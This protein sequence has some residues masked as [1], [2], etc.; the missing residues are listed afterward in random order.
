[1]RRPSFDEIF[2][3]WARDLS[4]RSTCER[5]QVGCL[6]VSGDNCRVLAIGYNGGA[7]GLSDACSGPE[8]V[9]T[10][11]CLHAEQNALVKLD[12]NDPAYRTLYTTLSPCLMCAKL[13]V[14]ARVSRV[15]YNEVYRDQ[16]GITLLQQAG[17][18]VSDAAYLRP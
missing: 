4:R 5:T 1:M 11:G 10:C 8:A 9:G 15:V 2:G 17:V 12:Y 7:R 13:L 16:S 18:L 14:N 3:E 6:I